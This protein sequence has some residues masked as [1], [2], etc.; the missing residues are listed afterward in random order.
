M[1]NH[2]DVLIIGGGVIGLTTAYYLAR[3]KLRVEIVDKSDFGQEAS[4]AGAG[5]LPPGNPRSAR[6]PIDQLRAHSAALFPT[7]S[8][9]LR[10]R[11]GVDNGFVQSGGLEFLVQADQV[12]ANEWREEGIVFEQL[13]EKKLREMEPA[14]APGLGKACYLPDMCQLRN[15]RHLKALL[16]ACQ[17][18]GVQLRPGTPACRFNHQGG[19][20]T[21]LESDRGQ[22]HAGRFIVA[23]GAWTGPVLEPLG[24][25]SGIHPVRG[26]IALLS[27]RAPLFRRILLWG[28]QYLVPRPDGR[29][30]VGSTEE[31]AGFEK[32]TTAAA[33]AELLA[34]A[35]R[36]V[37]ALSAA[38]L[39]RCWAGLRPG[40]PDGLPFLG[41]VPG[42]SNL[43][44][45]AGHFRA[46]IQLSPATALVMKEL[47]LGQ[48]LT[49]P[50]DSFRLDRAPAPRCQS[51]FRS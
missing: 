47:L 26:Q 25:K 38:G 14:L 43:Y 41:P 8:A 28:S 48:S 36:L 39:E 44:V 32:C 49:V 50:L 37:P 7:L 21:A 13:N 42:F 27:T 30:L 40:S 6:L 34:L 15:P 35:C 18:L 46:G 29:V 3:E 1:A 51:V 33:I 24:W 12:A 20:I 19:L 22:V 10:E 16:A 9:E 45:A 31:D 23:T 2:P 11:T 4:W 17:S 5:I